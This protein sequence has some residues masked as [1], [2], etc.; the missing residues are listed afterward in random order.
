[1]STHKQPRRWEKS[2]T[3]PDGTCKSV[4][5]EEAENGF[6][7]RIRSHNYSL[8][9]AGDDYK[10]KNYTRLLI[11]KKNPLEKLEPSIET[12]KDILNELKMMFGN[13]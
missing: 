8:S 1:M 12:D 9:E 6:V 10:S 5:V 4:E 11:S 13:D 3:H 7:V 2:E